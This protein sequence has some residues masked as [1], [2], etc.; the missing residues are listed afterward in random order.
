MGWIMQKNVKWSKQPAKGQLPDIDKLLSSS[1]A[2]RNYR[3]GRE[4]RQWLSD[5]PV[6]KEVI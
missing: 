5:K 6:G 1:S 2:S 3:R 4:D